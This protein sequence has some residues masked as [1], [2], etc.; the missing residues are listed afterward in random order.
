MSEYS[1]MK[2]GS[3]L[4]ADPGSFSEEELAAIASPVILYTKKALEICD[5]YVLHCGRVLV[6]PEDIVRCLQY[7][8]IDFETLL[9]SNSGKEELCH[10]YREIIGD[11][12]K[13]EDM[14]PFEDGDESADEKV[15]DGD[16][17]ANDNDDGDDGDDDDQLTC[18]EQKEGFKRTVETMFS[19]FRNNGKTH[20]EAATESIKLAKR[21]YDA[22]S[23]GSF[24][25]S[26]CPCPLCVCVNKRHMEWSSWEAKTPQE[27]H[28]KKAI[29]SICEKIQNGE[30]FV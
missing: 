1:F 29:N 25:E 17:D 12:L 21:G 22:D 28:M 9:N 3:S 18:E 8:A 15:G 2:S 4:V 13:N 16:S 19:I 10:T 30:S 5:I 24:C 14:V 20:N 26:I 6:Q 11:M 7:T 27:E 23:E